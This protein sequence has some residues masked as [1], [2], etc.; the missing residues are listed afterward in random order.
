MVKR[1]GPR[2]SR[3]LEKAIRISSRNYGHYQVCSETTSST[4]SRL[5]FTPTIAWIR[6]FDYA[7]DES[8]S[9]PADRLLPPEPDGALVAQHNHSPY[10]ATKPDYNHAR[11]GNLDTE[12]RRESR[13]KNF[14]KDIAYPREGG[15]GQQYV[16]PDWLNENMGDYSTPWGAS[17]MGEEDSEDPM[18]QKRRRQIWI[19][20]LHNNLLRSPI[21]PL[22]LRLTVWCFSAAALGLG[23]SIQYLSGKYNHPQGASALM[24]I[25]VDAVA[26]VYLVYITF[27]EY[28]SKPLGLRPPLAKA[29]LIL[30]DIFFIVFDSANLSLAFDS[31]SSVKGSCTVAQ[32]NSKVAPKNDLICDR[33][34]ALASVLLIALIA[35]LMTFSIS[36]LR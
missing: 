23:G 27:D 30:L 11:G 5:T 24:A 32:V 33:Q 31:L 21:V 20:R 22:I 6:S 34:K 19:L 18:R 28:T 35:W 15:V 10:T 26:L 17:L 25:I 8:E 3:P 2:K 16:T 1:L 12:P 29:R 7:A 36:V 9:S 4:N 13:W 14:S